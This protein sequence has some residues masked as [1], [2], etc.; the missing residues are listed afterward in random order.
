VKK[1]SDGSIARKT[2][3]AD[4]LSEL[5]YYRWCIVL[6][7]M[8]VNSVRVIFFTDWCTFFTFRWIDPLP[9]YNEV[10]EQFMELV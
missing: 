4:V 8:E 10:S 7:V 6:C 5:N 1:Q 3:S 9:V 2:M